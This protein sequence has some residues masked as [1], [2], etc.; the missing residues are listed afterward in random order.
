MKHYIDYMD[1]IS[2]DPAL[3]GKIMQ[4]AIQPKR[5]NR[6]TLRYAG[7]V[8]TAAVLLLGIWIMPS[9]ISNWR[10]PDGPPRVT[11]WTGNQGDEN[12]DIAVGADTQYDAHTNGE[13][14]PGQGTPDYDR[15][16][17]GG[18]PPSDLPPNGTADPEQGTDISSQGRPIPPRYD[19]QDID[20]STDGGTMIS[21]PSADR[22]FIAFFHEL[23]DRQMQA[24]FPNLGPGF[25]AQA[26]YMPDG[27]LIE[28][29][30]HAIDDN[31]RHWLR[32]RVAEDAIV[33]TVLFMQEDEPLVSYV[34]G[35]EVTAAVFGADE[36]GFMTVDFMLDNIAYHVTIHGITEAGK[37]LI[38]EVVNQ[39]ILGGPADL[40]VLADPVIP[41]LRN[42]M[43]TLEEA[44]R[45][46]DFG[47]FL[48]ANIPDRL[49]FDMA[50]RWID[51]HS[52]NLFTA[53]LTT[54]DS[55]SNE[56]VRWI[57]SKEAWYHADRFVSADDTHK[58]DRSLFQPPYAET[59]PDE[60]WQIH[61]N[62]IFRAE[63]FTFEV[64]QM[65][66]L[67]DD[68]QDRRLGDT[69]PTWQINFGVL[70]GDIV[71][72]VSTRGLTPKEVWEMLQPLR[73]NF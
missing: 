55:F 34:H 31:D 69:T 53:W 43:L 21:T 65:R 20:F 14:S 35:V 3:K 32:I 22:A 72:D 50:N 71:V 7:L 12:D 26:L 68:R 16:M 40:S 10:T 70:Y 64:L 67:W 56:Y 36:F 8:A 13:V 51:Q 24:V 19:I 57:V 66:A 54:D 2:V 45:D 27:S 11:Y 48:P 23:T 17:P 1:N 30:A 9:A 52:N 28:V 5:I 63:E 59:V 29:D 33:H 42:E 62:P 61:M 38:T 18:V 15:I 37:T 60:F 49:G 46:P 47:G 4:R 41:E 44:R 73:N 58:F 6:T 25:S 39:L